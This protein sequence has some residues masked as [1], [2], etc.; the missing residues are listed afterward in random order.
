MIKQGEKDISVYAD[1]FGIA[2]RQLIGILSSSILR[3]KEI[4]S[5]EYDLQWL[6]SKTIRPLDPAL[7]L[8]AGRQFAPHGQANFGRSRTSRYKSI[9]TKAYGRCI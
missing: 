6:S 3:G 8:F 9:R 2:E 5:F 7:H 1:W 4:F